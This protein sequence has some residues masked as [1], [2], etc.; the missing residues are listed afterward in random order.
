MRQRP[1]E[2]GRPGP[3]VPVDDGLWCVEDQVPGIPGARRR[4]SIIRRADGGLVFFN[5]VPLPDAQRYEVRARP[6]GAAGLR[7]PHQPA[8]RRRLLRPLMRLLDFSGPAPKLRRPV[9]RRVLRDGKARAEWVE[10]WPPS[11]ASQR[12]MPSH[13]EVQEQGVSAALRA[14]AATL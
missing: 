2:V 11:P 3:L 14:D 10:R 1:W 8:P 5:A 7:R 4:M 12:P 13:G 9:Q 6:P